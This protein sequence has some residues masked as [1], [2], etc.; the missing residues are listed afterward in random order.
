MLDKS[1]T[2]MNWEEGIMN[3]D[4]IVWLIA[5]MLWNSVI[6]NGLFL[7]LMPFQFK[8]RAQFFNMDIDAHSG[9]ENKSLESQIIIT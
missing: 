9:L 3:C 4:T 7:T 8:Q 1:K 2:N 5:Y 6:N